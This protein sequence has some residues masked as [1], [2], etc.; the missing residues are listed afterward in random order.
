VGLSVSTAGGSPVASYFAASDSGSVA[1][2]HVW[3]HFFGRQ[4]R[5]GE[6]G[7][8]ISQRPGW[9]YVQRWRDERLSC[10]RVECREPFAF[11]HSL[12]PSCNLDATDRVCWEGEGG[13]RGVS[14]HQE[15][16][17]MKNVGL[18]YSVVYPRRDF[19]TA[20]VLVYI[21][22]LDGGPSEVK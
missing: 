17:G 19:Q 11:P 20:Y 9:L 14:E 12:K 21:E 18:P 8:P 7:D 10:R 22:L 4:R 3:A 2:V 13:V 5:A 16:A 1:V 6:F 15:D